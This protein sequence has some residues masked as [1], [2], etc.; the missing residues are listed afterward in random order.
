MVR[1]LSASRLTR[2]KYP[3][4]H[5]LRLHPS[6]DAM[7]EARGCRAIG[8][9]QCWCVGTLTPLPTISSSVPYASLGPLGWEGK[10]FPAS[11]NADSYPRTRATGTWSKAGHYLGT[12]FVRRPAV[13]AGALLHFT[14]HR[15]TGDE[16][17]NHMSFHWSSSIWSCSESCSESE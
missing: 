7:R 12:R 10:S 6:C 1:S 8:P 16:A 2:C 9:S 3:Q 11:S 17:R 4:F 13:G 14:P 15:V 5:R